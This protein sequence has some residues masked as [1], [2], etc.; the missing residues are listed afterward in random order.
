MKLL[1][2]TAIKDLRELHKQLP[3]I[4]N[5]V[6]KLLS[7]RIKEPPQQLPVIATLET[8]DKNEPTAPDIASGIN[9]PISYLI[10]FLKKWFL[11]GLK[12]LVK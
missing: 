5:N 1:S 7:K 2:E 3:A 9:N 10:K 4:E 12:V 8:N 11:G 6:T